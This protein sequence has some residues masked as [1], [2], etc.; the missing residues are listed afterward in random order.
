MSSSWHRWTFPEVH[1]LHNTDE[2]TLSVMAEG[3]SESERFA[4]ELR[5]WAK[6]IEQWTT[7]IQSTRYYR[8]TSNVPWIIL[9][10]GFEHGENATSGGRL[11]VVVEMRST[12][13]D[14]FAQELRRWADH[15]EQFTSGA[16]SISSES[17]R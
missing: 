4:D 12:R 10:R 1:A 3:F 8:G 11:L 17:Q 2:V 9:M 6:W 7:E 14:W 16:R 13:L 5:A 15:I